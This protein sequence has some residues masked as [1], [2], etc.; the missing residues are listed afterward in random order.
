MTCLGGALEHAIHGEADVVQ[1]DLV[2]ELLASA[3]VVIE[4][5][6]ASLT[7]REPQDAE[8]AHI[9]LQ[10]LSTVDLVDSSEDGQVGDEEKVVEQLGI[11]GLG[12]AA[13]LWPLVECM[14]VGKGE[15]G[16][17]AAEL[18]PLVECMVVGAGKMGVEAADLWPPVVGIGMMSVV[19]GRRPRRGGADRRRVD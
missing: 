13:E 8:E 6:E 12:V 1:T 7:P 16:V 17:E 9:L 18:G 2:Y 10:S 5:H 14:I 11:R 15:M 4:N 19:L 3:I